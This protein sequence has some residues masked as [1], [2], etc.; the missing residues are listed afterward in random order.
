[1]CEYNSSVAA[2]KKH[3]ATSP[4]AKYHQPGEIWNKMVFDLPFPCED[5][6]YQGDPRIQSNEVIQ[7]GNDICLLLEV[8]GKK[9]KKKRVPRATPTFRR[10]AKSARSAAHATPQVRIATP[11]AAKAA[12]THVATK[13]KKQRQK[14]QTPQVFNVGGASYEL[15]GNKLILLKTNPPPNSNP[16]PAAAPQRNK[17]QAA[18]P[19]P[20]TGAQGHSGSLQAQGSVNTTTGGRGAAG[21]G[22]VP[23][24]NPT[25]N[26]NLAPDVQNQHLIQ[27]QIAPA[28]V[29]D[30]EMPDADRDDDKEPES[31]QKNPPESNFDS[32]AAGLVEI[33]DENGTV[34][35]LTREEAEYFAQEQAARGLITLQSPK[36]RSALEISQG[37]VDYEEGTLEFYD[38]EQHHSPASERDHDSQMIDLNEM[39]GP[40]AE[41]ENEESVNRLLGTLMRKKIKINPREWFHRP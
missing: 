1:M 25:L 33:E 15:R 28:D 14:T 4:D 17:G 24:L 16:N 5:T 3:A 6:F 2:L 21:G 22:A 27:P 18:P 7:E 20:T 40:V 26:T 9:E 32:N 34:I 35:T 10:V 8:I 12:A 39:I 38:H 30:A 41:R 13:L 31:V 36:K 37:S 29:E 11:T 23:A 19:V